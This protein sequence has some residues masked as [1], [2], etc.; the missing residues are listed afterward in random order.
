M[1]HTIYPACTGALSVCS[2][3]SGNVWSVL[4]E[5]GYVSETWIGGGL[6]D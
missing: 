4:E 1:T 2:V 6:P 5:A 3:R